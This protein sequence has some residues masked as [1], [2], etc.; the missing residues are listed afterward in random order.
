MVDMENF[1]IKTYLSKLLKNWVI[2]VLC[3]IIGL[4]GAF[5]YSEFVATPLYESKAKV[6]YF[7]SVSGSLSTST[8]NST[9]EMIENSLVVLNDNITFS[10]VAEIVNEQLGTDYTSA[11]V[12]RWVSY[13]REGDTFFLKIIVRTPDPELSAVI[14]N[15]VLALAPD[16]INEYVA[17]IP[18]IPLDNAHVNYDPV[19]PNTMKNMVLGLLLALVLVCGVI[20]LVVFFDNTV[21]DVEKLRERYD[22]SVLGTIPNISVYAKK[23][24]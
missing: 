16:L 15:A 22:L 17:N 1:D 10:K 9:Y 8:L 19:S 21:S 23:H 12:G 5:I 6:S 18:V 7:D 24:V 13:A 4:S 2:I 20:F 14:C 11:Q 3:G